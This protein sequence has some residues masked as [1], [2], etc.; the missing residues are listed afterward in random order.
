MNMLFEMPT[1][2][3]TMRHN[4]KNGLAVNWCILSAFKGHLYLKSTPIPKGIANV[5]RLIAIM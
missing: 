3:M 1:T 4:M 2:G 5:K